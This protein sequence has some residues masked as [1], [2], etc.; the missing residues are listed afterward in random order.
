MKIQKQTIEKESKSQIEF[1]DIT[2]D[3]EEIVK[4]SKMQ[5][6]QV[7]VFSGHSTAGIAINENE[8]LLLQ[9]FQ[10]LL[11]RLVPIDERYSHDLF[12]LKRTAR[13]DGRSNGHSHCKN[14]LI[15]ASEIV[16]VEDGKMLLG[17]HQSIF[18]V[19]MDGARKRKV[20][21]QVIGE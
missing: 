18:L 5:N 8:S 16:P 1:I 10:R 7:L 12:E 11:Y 20:V 3:V 6:G 2:H 17:E 21:V 4:E 13:S 9:D 15:G 19:E 14:L